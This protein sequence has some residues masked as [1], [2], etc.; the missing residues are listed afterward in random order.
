MSAYGRPRIVALVDRQWWTRGRGR[1]LIYGLCLDPEDDSGLINDCPVFL[2]TAGAG[3][4]RVRVREPRTD[5][6]Y[7]DR[8]EAM[9]AGLRAFA[10]TVRS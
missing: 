5:E 9:R 10:G 6:V 4:W 7:R 2:E 3:R 1:G 8:D